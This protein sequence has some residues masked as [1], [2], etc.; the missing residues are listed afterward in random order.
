MYYYPLPLQNFVLVDFPS[1][2]VHRDV[3]R[4]QS[5][6]NWVKTLVPHVYIPGEHHK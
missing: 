5:I 4:P 3:T 6:P 2:L 1:K